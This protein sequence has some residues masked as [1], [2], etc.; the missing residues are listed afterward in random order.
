MTT[1]ARLQ[2]IQAVVLMRV[3]EALERA[4]E[5]VRRFPEREASA[6][7]NAL[8]ILDEELQ[9]EVTRLM[10]DDRVFNAVQAEM[11]EPDEE[12]TP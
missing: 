2:A 12:S 8:T 11:A 9:A 5:R 7:C 1:E 4:V 6:C 3:Q 10:K